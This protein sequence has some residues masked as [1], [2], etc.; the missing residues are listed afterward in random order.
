MIPTLLLVLSVSLLMMTCGRNEPTPEEIRERQRQKEIEEAKRLAEQLKQERPF[1]FDLHQKKAIKDP[2]NVCRLRGEF[3][4]MDMGPDPDF[5][6][7]GN[8]AVYHDKWTNIYIR[9]FD[10]DFAR[11]KVLRGGRNPRW[12]KSYDAPKIIYERYKLNPRDW[13]GQNL[14]I[15]IQRLFTE[16]DPQIITEEPCTNPYFVNDDKNIVYQ[17]GDRYILM[18]ER[19]NEREITKAEYERLIS[20]RYTIDCNWDV[21]PE[22]NGVEGVWIHTKDNRYHAMVGR[23]SNIRTLRIIPERCMI[24]FWSEDKAGIIRLQPF[25]LPQIHLGG[26][27]GIEYK[28]GQILGVYG[29]ARS[30]LTDEVIGIDENDWRGNVRVI[31]VTEDGAVAE[32]QTRLHQALFSVGDA[33]SPLDDHSTYAMIT[34]VK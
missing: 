8:A 16:A 33:V 1:D 17:A 11:Q 27:S 7:E 24:Y 2:G 14:G 26:G 20:E 10:Q 19:M 12:A 18:D 34:E 15:A 6:W 32:Y 25:A 3:L 9:I 4:S 22:Y 30:P 31:S 13:G 28:V 23:A 21:T 5:Y 29:V